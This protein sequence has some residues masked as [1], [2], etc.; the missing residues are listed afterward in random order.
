MLI[1]RIKVDKLHGYLSYDI[2]LNDKLTFIHGINGTGKT[3]L[4]LSVISLVQPDLRWLLTTEFSSIDAKF[5]SNGEKFS[6]SCIQNDEIIRCKISKGR[7]ELG[8]WEYSKIE[9][10]NLIRIFEEDDSPTRE[11]A[12]SYFEKI[13]ED[14]SRST[15]FRAIQTVPTPLFLGLER[16]SVRRRLTLGRSFRHG[17]RWRQRVRFGPLAMGVSL[18]ERLIEEKYSQMTALRKRLDS[19]FRKKLILTVFETGEPG[20]IFGEFWPDRALLRKYK[21]IAE[22][23]PPILKRI[24]FV[25]SDLK[26][27]I[28]PFFSQLIDVAET[29]IEKHPSPGDYDKMSSEDRK[30]VTKW[31]EISTRLPIL[32]RISALI[33]EYEAN[34]KHV[35]FDTVRFCDLINEF[36]VDSNKKISITETGNVSIMLPNKKCQTP[37]DLSSGEMQIFLLIAHVIFNEDIERANCLIV[38]EPEISLHVQWQEKFVDAIL[39]ANPNM[40]YIM[41]THSPAIIGDR[42]TEC[43]AIHQ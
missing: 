6:A 40:Q 15:Y 14:F 23:V 39:S 11:R 13:D 5:E 35:Y 16:T 18:A 34:E 27:Y 37:Q 4:V 31:I 24:D 29:L 25:D 43:I 17:P 41:A 20:R 26:R 12:E 7:K 36:F 32:D 1:D 10:D 30:L 33:E 3:S 9:R 21:S 38:D 19:D 42:V 22:K 8:S 28:E 2:K